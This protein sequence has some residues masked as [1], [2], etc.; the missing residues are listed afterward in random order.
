MKMRKWGKKV[1]RDAPLMGLGSFRAPKFRKTVGE[2]VH[3]IKDRLTT[4]GLEATVEEVEQIVRGQAPP[5]IVTTLVE[6]FVLD[7]RNRGVKI[8]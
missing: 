1:K 3:E 6:A 7:E 2:V 5:G 4:M 8:V